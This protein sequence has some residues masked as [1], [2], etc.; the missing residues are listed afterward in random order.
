MAS[1]L[2]FNDANDG[3]RI[4]LDT[5]A[6]VAAISV[7]QDTTDLMLANGHVFRVRGKLD[8]VLDQAPRLKPSK[9]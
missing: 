3:K 1:F 6:I 8:T 5:E 7:N 2:K 9:G 4:V